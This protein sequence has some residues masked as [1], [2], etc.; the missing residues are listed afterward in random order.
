MAT[1]FSL[2]S[3][4]ER[5]LLNSGLSQSISD[6]ITF[7][8]AIITLI[9]IL[10]I[11]DT[12]FSHIVLKIVHKIS[13]KIKSK[14]YNTMV[15]HHFFRKTLRFLASLMLIFLVEILF[16]GFEIKLVHNTIIIA[17]TLSIY[18]FILVL[19]AFID[20][21]NDMYLTTSRAK[22]M[23]IKG[24]LQIA[25][26][27]IVTMAILS[28]VSLYMG[29]DLRV[30]FTTLGAG[31]VVLT[32]VFKDTLLGFTASIQLSAQDMVRLGDW[33]VVEKSGANGTV[34]DLNI[35]TC[36]VLNWDKTTSMIPIYMLV[37]SPFINWRTM[38]E[39]NGRRF[40]MPFH[41][42]VNSIETISKKDI[43][44]FAFS[45]LFSK[46]YNKIME[47][48]HSHS[49]DETT[50]I[51]IFRAYA[52]AYLRQNDLINSDMMLLVRYL[53]MS[54]NGIIIELYGFTKTIKWYNYESTI[55]TVVEQMIVVAMAL[56]LK[57]YQ[58]NTNILTSKNDFLIT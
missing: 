31:V 24:Y 13:N 52:E 26:I 46:Y 16:H 32:L 22:E 12:I 6:L 23:S 54:D 56:N 39:G 17:K 30:V 19:N 49:Q 47:Y 4:L 50:N 57:I 28:V 2:L 45:P 11:L 43:E 10:F 58:K 29:V 25:K 40:K 21:I 42:D 35:N 55:A 36:K 5:I 37:S 20:T 8:S 34:I 53:P 27:I 33:I 1:K 41:I 51:S 7:L 3:D 9:V 48:K 14:W 15:S 18:C 44:Q 38:E